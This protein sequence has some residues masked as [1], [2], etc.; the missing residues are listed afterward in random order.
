[1]LLLYH[2]KE[3]L[4]LGAD[5]SGI[6]PPGLHFSVLPPL[7]S[8]QD[9]ARIP[10]ARRGERREREPSQWTQLPFTSL[11]QSAIE[12]FH[13]QCWGPNF[14]TS[15]SQ[16]QRKTR[17]VTALGKR[18]AQLKPGI[19]LPGTKTRIDGLASSTF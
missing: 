8:H 3:V 6:R 4:S 19:L 5:F 18:S 11:P 12:L 16:P 10:L 15:H 14:I 2:A 1:M 13:L 17:Q 7:H 9:M